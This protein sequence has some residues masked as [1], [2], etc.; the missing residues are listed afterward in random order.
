MMRPLSSMLLEIYRLGK[1]ATE[2]SR[3]SDMERIDQ[4]RDEAIKQ[5]VTQAIESYKDKTI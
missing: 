2:E 4:I 3:M 5:I 1:T